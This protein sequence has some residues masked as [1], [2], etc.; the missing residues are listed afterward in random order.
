ML[1]QFQAIHNHLDVMI[2][3][4]LVGQ[5]MIGDPCIINI[6]QILHTHYIFQGNKEFS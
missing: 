6:I 2:I 4:I 1:D 3:E 5:A